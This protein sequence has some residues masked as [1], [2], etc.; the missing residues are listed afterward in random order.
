MSFLGFPRVP[1]GR[2]DQTLGLVSASVDVVV[3]GVTLELE[4]GVHDA[5]VSRESFLQVVADLLRFVQRHLA[6]DDDVRGQ[7]GNV[8]RHR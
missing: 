4:R 7:R 5:V 6:F 1:L 3:A 8:R 2:V